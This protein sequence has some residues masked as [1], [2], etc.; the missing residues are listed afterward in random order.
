MPLSTLLIA[1]SLGIMD[2]P[3][4]FADDVRFLSKY[5]STIVL[6]QGNAAV[7]VVAD[8]QGR[9]MTSTVDAAKGVGNGWINYEH[10]ASGK[11]VPH[12]NAFGGEERFWL[13]PEGGQ[14]SVFFKGGDPFNLEHWQT[15]PLIDTVS[16]P[17]ASKSA[18]QVTFKKSASLQNY[19]GTTFN[20]DIT[21]KVQMLNSSAVTKALGFAPGSGVKVAAYE[22][23][24]TL[25][26]TGSDAW[27][28]DTGLLS[29]WILAM[30][31]HSS[32]TTVVVPYNAGDE[33]TM[34]PIVNDTYFG[35]VPDDRISVSDKAVYFK[36]D[37]QFRSKI[38]LNPHRS[39]GV[40]GSYDPVRGML[41]VAQYTQKKGV[42]DYVNSM[43]ELQ[44][45]P[46]G[47]DVV[48]SYN[49]GP[50]APGKKPLGPFYEIE[51]S[52]AAAAL[53]PGGSIT[54]VHRT[55]HFI[56]SKADLDKIA[57]KTLGVGCDEIANGLK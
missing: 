45:D 37:G 20:M 23:V 34:G 13:G 56:G 10:I 15:P 19:W 47:G 4:S 38:G 2:T 32:T 6:R 17:V 14:F 53:Q 30:L 55:M 42:T 16:Y 44:A 3:K 1:A 24:N 8:Y 36:A 57:R 28:K 54:H 46:Y 12:M 43:W 25:K 39:K 40:I 29:I 52:S 21:R 26:N 33:S 31:K 7:A 50:P 51:S 41:T 18:S 11:L 5:K 22:T 35:K 49:D 9:V 48:N 27:K